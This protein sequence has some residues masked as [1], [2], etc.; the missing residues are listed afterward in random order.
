MNLGDREHRVRMETQQR[1]NLDR[2]FKNSNTDGG[3]PLAASVASL[4]VAQQQIDLRSGKT[5]VN[6]IDEKFGIQKDAGL[7]SSTRHRYFHLPPAR[8]VTACRLIHQ[9]R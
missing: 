3:F 9:C 1:E 6:K 7:G 8:A 4:L 2:L 5:E